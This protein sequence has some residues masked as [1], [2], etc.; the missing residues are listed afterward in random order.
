L[1][2]TT[3]A[4][5]AER[6]PAGTLPSQ[7]SD[8]QFWQLVTDLSE[9]NGYFRSDNLV[10]N[11]IG[12]QWVIPDLLATVTSGGV[13]MGVGPEQNFTYIAALRPRMAFITDVR[14][15]N[16]HTHLMY[17]ALFELSADRADFVSRLFTKARPEGLSAGSS[18]ADIM[19]AY[20]DIQTS[21]E[22]AYQANLKALKDHLTKTHGLPLSAE[23]LGGIE[24]VYHSFYWFGPSI[25]YNSTSGGGRGFSTTYYDLMVATDGGGTP[26]S[27]LASEENFR[28][29]QDLHRRNLIVPVVG[30]FA[31]PKALRAVGDYV[32][33][34]GSFVM[35][36]YLS[37]VEQYLLQD[38]LWS[39]F[40]ANA[41]SLPLD[42]RS[43]FIR[44][45]SGGG[46]G[47][48]LVNDLGN[49]RAE[50]RVCGGPPQ[51]AGVTTRE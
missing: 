19:N 10:S 30:N 4:G 5:R 34:H 38:G 24:Y 6:Q 26:R 12:L 35:A 46:R 31:G 14:R 44:S 22:P 47:R 45:L 11:E 17:K 21:A 36:Y 9:N 41:A 27:F 16:L 49:I 51:P 18:A 15:G 23:D 1:V 39:R 43:A 25:T 3:S 28:V 32:R 29:L 7:L 40:C 50:T 42:D 20:W 37:N 13:Y 2:L 33:R 8:Q 48:G